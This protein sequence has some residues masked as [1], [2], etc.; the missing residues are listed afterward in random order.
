MSGEQ[1]GGTGQLPPRPAGERTGEWR[2]P[3]LKP[4]PPEVLA[5]ALAGLRR[6]DD[7]KRPVAAGG[8]SNGTRSARRQELG[9]RK[10]INQKEELPR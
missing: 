1:P 4:V 2:P 3:P 8:V 9:E 10:R 7:E 5:R 6:L